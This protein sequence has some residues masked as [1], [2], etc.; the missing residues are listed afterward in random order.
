MG[1]HRYKNPPI[2]EALC[3]FIFETEKG[4][5]PNIL[6]LPGKLQSELGAD[7]TGQ[8][9]QQ[10]VQFI[11]AA[12]DATDANIALQNRLHRI[13]LPTADGTRLISIGSNALAVSMLASYT[14][15]SD[16]FFPRIKKAFSAYKKITNLEFVKRIGIRYIN[17]LKIAEENADPN[18]F[19]TLR[20]PTDD[21]V[22]GKLTHITKRLEFLT[23][24]KYKIVITFAA[25]PAVQSKETAFL[26]DI[27]VIWDADIVSGEKN[28]I[29]MVD[30]LHTVEGQTFEAL[31]TDKARELFNA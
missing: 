25:N 27:D 16:E 9:R 10:R 6:T 7:Y 1:D 28:I 17:E 18:D 4:S 29:G 13:Q 30:K 21:I 26:L 24:E 19:F 5:L 3:E 12:P 8:P 31:V 14:S 20:D 15:W 11:R 22:K 2:I 23:D